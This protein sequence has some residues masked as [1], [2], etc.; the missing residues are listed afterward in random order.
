MRT[1][2]NVMYGFAVACFAAREHLPAGIGQRL[3]RA[4][5][6][7]LRSDLY[8]SIYRKALR[9]YASRPYGGPITTF[10]AKGLSKFHRQ[11]W[12]PLALGELSVS[13][14]PAGHLS[15]VSPPHSMELAAAFDRFLA[16]PLVTELPAK[17][18]WPRFPKRDGVS[19]T[20]S[21]RKSLAEV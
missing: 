17:D 20:A 14:I 18:L 13:E 11:H 3:I 12:Q 1:A 8:A 21:R 2:K 7:A 9:R 19:T 10:S 5:S 16:G 6:H 4:P 15:I